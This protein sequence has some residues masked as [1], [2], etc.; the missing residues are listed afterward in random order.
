MKAPVTRMTIFG[1]IF[2][3]LKTNRYHDQTTVLNDRK[4]LKMVI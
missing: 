2:F 1:R 3:I 4:H